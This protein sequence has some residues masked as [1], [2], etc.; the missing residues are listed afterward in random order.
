MTDQNGGG[1]ALVD[2]DRDEQIDL[3][4][5]NGSVFENP[6][7][8][9]N[10]SNRLFRARGDFRYEDVTIAAGLKAH[11]FGMG[12]AAGDYDN[13]GFMDLF[14]ACYGRDRLWHNNGDGT[15]SEVTESAGVDCESWGTSAAMSDLDGDGFL[16]IY[17]VNYVEWSPTEPLCHPADHPEINTVCSPMERPGQPDA[18]YRNLGDGRFEETGMSAG[19]ARADG[20]GMALTI[21]DLD[22]DGWPD[23]Y[24][25]NDTTPN[26]LFRNLGSMRFEEV[27]AAQGVAVSNDGVV[28]AGMGVGCADIDRNGRL[29][30]CVTNFRNQLN[31]VYANMSY[32]GFEAVNTPM[33]LDLKSRSPLGFGII[34]ADF[35]MDSW[36]D[37]FVANGHIWDLTSLGSGY[38]Y[39]MT[40][41]LLANQKGTRFTDV[42]ASS[43][44]YFTRRW[45]GRSAAIGDLDHDGDSDLVVTHLGAV[46]AILRNDSRRAKKKSVR[47]ELIGLRASRQPLGATVALIDEGQR[48]VATVPS[49][50]SFQAS[51]D[52]QVLFAYGGHDDRIEAVQVHWPGGSLE[53]WKDV[54]VQSGKVY[55]V[56][57]TGVS[58]TGSH[59]SP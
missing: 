8:E 50:G 35:D 21:A 43:G 12:T 5:V 10:A 47:L 49:G 41:Q 14:V 20:K 17:V 30:L 16:D 54:S 11:N 36:P 34:L 59:A 52:P 25:V 38:E 58:G 33:G 39:E 6:S 51:F 13:D 7:N 42:S 18:L 28:G 19:I 24:V 1:V 45:L 55:L 32:G 48:Y 53:E 46:P 27:A 9:L 40:P 2:F 29:D 56:Q 44:E 37:M 26:F 57:G 23:V 31:D 4:F 3:Y 15:F 22:G